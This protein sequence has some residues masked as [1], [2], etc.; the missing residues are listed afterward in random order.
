MLTHIFA[1]KWITVNGINY[2]SYITARESET[3][4]R[5]G[6]G[7]IQGFDWIIDRQHKSVFIKKNG[8]PIVSQKNVAGYKAE[9]HNDKLI[10]VS[11]DI[12]YKKF[13]VGDEITSV[14]GVLVAKSNICGLLKQLSESEDWKY[15][16]IIVFPR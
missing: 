4:S 16:D 1:N 2:S 3:E 10:V 13:A 6:M 12:R 9:I 8:N 14:N 15:L 5:V 11:H 7:F